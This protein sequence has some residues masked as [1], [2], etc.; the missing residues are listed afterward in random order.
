M[1]VRRFLLLIGSMLVIFCMDSSKVFAGESNSAIVG[2]DVVIQNDSMHSKST[3]ADPDTI[4]V[5]TFPKTGSKENSVTF[6]MGLVITTFALI[7]IQKKM[8]RGIK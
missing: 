5:K 2:Y 7:F 3:I 6:I 8:I 4:S 1:K